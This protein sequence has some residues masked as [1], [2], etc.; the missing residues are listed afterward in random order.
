M[1]IQQ[2]AQQANQNLRKYN[3]YHQK[4]S[5][6]DGKTIFGTPNLSKSKELQEILA[7][8]F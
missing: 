1:G 8:S 4:A 6:T 7:K 5:K 2:L 3:T